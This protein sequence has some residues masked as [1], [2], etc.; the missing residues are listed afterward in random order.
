MAKKTPKSGKCLEEAKS[1]LPSELASYDDLFK[2]SQF[3]IFLVDKESFKILDT[4]VSCEMFLSV[5]QEELE[6]QNILDWIKEKDRP[7]FS[8]ELRIIHHRYYPHF[9]ENH[10]VTKDGAE[11]IINC[12][13][14]ILPL[15]DGRQVIQIIAKDVTREREMEARLKITLEDLKEANQKLQILSTTDEMTQLA[16]FR[17]F[18]S[19]LEKESERALRYKRPYTVIFGD[20]DYFKIY[21]DQNGHLAGD[22][23][24]KQVSKI[25]RES[26]RK[27]DIPARYGGEEFAILCPELSLENAR[28]VAER[29]RRRVESFPFEHS[30]K[31]PHGKVTMSFGIASFP[32]HGFRAND[33][34]RSADQAL[35]ESKEAGRNRVTVQ[36]EVK[37]SSSSLDEIVRRQRK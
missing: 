3:P 25:L 34:L 12:S 18:M 23:L 26:C 35:Y 5:S 21:N 16:N 9:S 24:L 32:E 10:W 15:S 11:K 2:R 31:Q 6:G 19:L 22:K 28:K 20:L 7:R 14:S 1:V 17:N 36:K 27:T 4:N 8:K 13:V 33:V 37:E 29:I 30:D